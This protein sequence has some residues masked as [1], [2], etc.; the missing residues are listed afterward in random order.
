[1]GERERGEGAPAPP[2]DDPLEAVISLAEAARLSGLAAHT[3]TL[4]AER[5]KLRARKVGHSWITTRYWLEEYLAHHARNARR[6]GN[7]ESAGDAGSVGTAGRR[8]DPE[9][10]EG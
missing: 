9:C 2:A 7:G 4:Q 5:G 10:G 1:M 6:A 3:L 8:L